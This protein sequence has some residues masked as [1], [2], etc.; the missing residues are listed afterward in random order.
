MDQ[1]S[2]ET[3]LLH[4]FVNV[5]HSAHQQMELRRWHF[6]QNRC[7]VVTV[8]QWLMLNTLEETGIS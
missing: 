5:V 4:L 1:L 6:F 8:D 3:Y 7:A 2:A